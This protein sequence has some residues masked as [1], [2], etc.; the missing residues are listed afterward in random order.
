MTET[1]KNQTEILETKKI[2]TKIQSSVDKLNNQMEG[3]RKES[4]NE[5]IQQ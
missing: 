2:I 1:K 5:M 4:A 3:Q